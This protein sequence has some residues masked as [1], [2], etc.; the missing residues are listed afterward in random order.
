[1]GKINLSTDEINKRLN[2]QN[3]LATKAELDTVKKGFEYKQDILN[4]GTNLIGEGVTINKDNR[5]IIT[6]KS[7]GGGGGGGTT[8]YNALNNKPAINGHEL[9]GDLSSSDLDLQESMSDE[10]EYSPNDVCVL[11]ANGDKTMLEIYGATEERAGVM[12]AAHVNALTDLALKEGKY[13]FVTYT[14]PADG[15]VD[16]N[17]YKRPTIVNCANVQN[18]VILNLATLY[19]EVVFDVPA[20]IPVLLQ[21]SAANVQ[22]IGEADVTKR[23]LYSFMCG[24]LVVGNFN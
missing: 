21:G 1:M 15:A 11:N 5:G 20:D 4:P 13:D 17:R 7:D 10:C 24:N 3:V 18:V 23:R 9:E 12:T 14:T 8:D 6:I 2:G 16:V 19:Y 22:I